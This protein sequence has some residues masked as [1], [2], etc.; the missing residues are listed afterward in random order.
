MVSTKSNANEGRTI[1][2][3][4]PKEGAHP[5]PISSVQGTVYSNSVVVPAAPSYTGSAPAI[6]AI[7]FTQSPDVLYRVM[8]YVPLRFLATAD[9]LN[10]IGRFIFTPTSTGT[11]QPAATG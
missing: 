6:S 9:N 5:N 4:P 2:P 1:L 11:A 7:S 10:P 8:V 3:N